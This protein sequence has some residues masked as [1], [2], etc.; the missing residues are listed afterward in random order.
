[1]R[2]HAAVW[3]F[4][5]DNG[6]IYAQ[7]YARDRL[8]LQGT[9][10]RVADSKWLL[11]R[12]GVALRAAW[13][14]LPLEE[15]LLMLNKTADEGFPRHL[16]DQG[17]GIEDERTK[18]SK[19][20]T[21]S[22]SSTK[23]SKR[24]GS[25]SQKR[26]SET[27][28]IKQTQAKLIRARNKYYQ[29]LTAERN[30]NIHTSYNRGSLSGVIDVVTGT[31][32]SI[33]LQSRDDDG[34]TTA[35]DAYTAIATR[36]ATAFV[37]MRGIAMFPPEHGDVQ[38]EPSQ[39]FSENRIRKVHDG[40]REA[41]VSAYEECRELNVSEDPDAPILPSTFQYFKKPAGIPTFNGS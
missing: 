26:V 37:S 21:R 27:T 16:I 38:D 41:A 5:S 39:E 28:N 22:H 40:Y 33:I 29:V 17:I 1:M 2:A 9:Y 10:L 15:R 6:S 32:E 4:A 8:Q 19:K 14:V 12:G 11:N 34:A 18:R 23:K 3:L 30:L 35:E 20:G 7:K 31:V 24:E 13:S 25:Q 36:L